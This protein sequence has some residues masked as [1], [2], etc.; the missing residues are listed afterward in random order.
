MIDGDHNYHTVSEEL[1]LIGERA[2][3]A[4]CRCSC[5]TTCCWPHG[6]RDDYF[7]AEQIPADAR[8]PVGRRR[9]RD[10]PG[11][12]GRRAR[13][14][15]PTPVGSARGR[16][17]QRRADGDR[18]LRGRARAASG[19]RSCR[20][21][22][23]SR[24]PGTPAARTPAPLGGAARPVRPPP[25][26]R[27][28]RGQPRRAAGPRLPAP[29]R[30][31]GR[32]EPSSRAS[33]RCWSGCSIRARSRSPS[34]SRGC[35][36]RA[37]SRPSSRSSRRTRS[38][39]R[40]TTVSPLSRVRLA[41]APPAVERPQRRGQ[42]P[43]SVDR[44]SPPAR[45]RARAPAR[46]ASS[47]FENAIARAASRRA[48]ARPVRAA[49]SPPR[50]RPGLGQRLVPLLGDLDVRLDPHVEVVDQ[51]QRAVMDG[52]RGRRP[53]AGVRPP[54][55]AGRSRGRIR[56]RA[57]A[58]SSKRTFRTTQGE[59]TSS[60]PSTAST[61][62]GGG[63]CR[64]PRDAG[65]LAAAVLLV[66]LARPSRTTTSALPPRDPADAAARRR[67]RPAPTSGSRE[68]FA[69]L[70][71]ER[72]VAISVWRVHEH[73]RLEVVASRPRP[74]GSGCRSGRSARRPRTRAPRESGSAARRI[75][76]SA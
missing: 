30:D 58:S 62:A 35:A 37:G 10:L 50:R 28:A 15:S 16:P 3:G 4:S 72:R 39:A 75:P 68:R 66:A 29:D 23:A 38:A 13:A 44:S 67:T 27:A 8:H 74:R 47:D 59:S 71:A 42:S 1:R 56:G 60:C 76:G 36:Q 6:R 40:S 19:S 18:G 24:S 65:E 21:S 12:P 41:P 53:P 17:A 43:R 32:S 34:G 25:G 57:A 69:H 33:G 11:R 2:A 31:L 61:S 55:P 51:L 5:S 63:R 70:R 49:S 20:R 7:D 14:A 26:A 22:S 54:A 9:R 45:A 73:Q 46:R 48:S 52:A 64:R